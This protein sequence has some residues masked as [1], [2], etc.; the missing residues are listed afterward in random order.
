MLVAEQPLGVQ[1][2]RVLG[3]VLAVHQQVLPVHVDLH[4]VDPL[5]AQLVDDVQRH[6]DV[7]HHDLH[8]RLGVLVLEEELD[9]VLG[10][11]L[12]GQSHAL[13][14]PLP[15]VRVGRLEGVV[16]ALDARPDD[17]VR[18]DR[19]RE[20]GA[21]H[22]ALDG[23]GAHLRIWAHQPAA[24]EDRVEVHA[25]GDAVDVVAVERR[26]Y[27]PTGSPARAPAGSETR[28]RRSGPRGRRPRAPPSRAP[29]RCAR[30]GSP[31]AR[32]GSP[33][34]RR[35]RCPGRSSWFAHL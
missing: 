25:R 24:A 17:V 20:V 16:V 1:Q 15:R 26:L 6:A 9:A 22:G 10:A 35:P 19:P 14:E 21:V 12:R 11:L 23:L 28:S 18:A 31:W 30:A 2:R 3:Q 27:R 33:S 7:A 34:G 5:A 8:R 29:A 4:V 13:D 32:S